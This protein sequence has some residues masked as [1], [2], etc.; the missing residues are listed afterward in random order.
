MA[1]FLV[2]KYVHETS[3]SALLDCDSLPDGRRGLEDVDPFDKLCWG[4]VGLVLL[5]C[6]N[7][8]DPGVHGVDVCR[9]SGV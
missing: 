5:L 8:S 9:A 6:E 7:L 2:A 1:L 3:I 4:G